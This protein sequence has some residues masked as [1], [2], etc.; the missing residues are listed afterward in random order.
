MGNNRGGT[1]SITK[2]INA[3]NRIKSDLPTQIGN[4]AVTFFKA[5]FRKQGWEDEGLQPWK[6]RKGIAGQ[7]SKGRAILVKTGALRRSPE[8]VLANWNKVRIVSNLPYSAVHNEG[9]SANAWGK[10]A[11]K[12][13]KRKF[14]GRSRKLHNEIRTL[15]ERRLNVVFK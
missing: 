12:M 13:P 15:I 6:L 2:K 4:K 1:A 11:F 7:L 8:L 10:K 3:L 14:M 9:G 5:S